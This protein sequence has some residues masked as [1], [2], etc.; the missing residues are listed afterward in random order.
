MN[1]T[2]VSQHRAFP[3]A[4][5]AFAKAC[6]C[7]R[8]RDR[9]RQSSP[10]S[11]PCPA[12]AP[13]SSEA[14]MG[15]EAAT[16][17]LPVALARVLD[18]PPAIHPRESPAAAGSAAII[19]QIQEP[20]FSLQP[21]LRHFV[22]PGNEKLSLVCA[23]AVDV[24]SSLWKPLEISRRIAC[25]LRRPNRNLANAGAGRSRTLLVILSRRDN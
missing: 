16:P 6:R 18:F 5:A 25:G 21:T 10:A 7:P 23:E 3:A 8:S 2:A 22:A 14:G 24:R 4:Y 20:R 15:E 13:K 19:R 12:S 11:G 17:G 1:S 9:V